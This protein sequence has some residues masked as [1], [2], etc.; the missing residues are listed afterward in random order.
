MLDILRSDFQ[1]FCVFHQILL[2]MLDRSSQAVAVV[3]VFILI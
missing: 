3:L 1:V 2:L